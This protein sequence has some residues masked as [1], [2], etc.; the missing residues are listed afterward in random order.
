M[1]ATPVTY[2]TSERPLKR[3]LLALHNCLQLFAEP[4]GLRCG[5]NSRQR[6]AHHSLI[7]NHCNMGRPD[8]PPVIRPLKRGT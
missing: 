5:S 3:R 7:K 6:L 8:D 2:G 1:V 4:C